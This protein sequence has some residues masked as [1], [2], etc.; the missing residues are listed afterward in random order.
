MSPQTRNLI[1]GTGIAI[2]LITLTAYAGSVRTED[3]KRSALRADV[4]ALAAAFKYPVMEANSLRT[5]AGRD[6]LQPMLLEV[7]RAGGFTHIVLTDQKGTVLATTKGELE[8]E[9]VPKNELPARARVEREDPGLKAAAPI[10]LGS[11]TIGYL[12]VETDR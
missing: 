12:F 5:D 3:A 2:V 7:A 8:A 11:N 9:T 1:V 4:A 10:K 6:R